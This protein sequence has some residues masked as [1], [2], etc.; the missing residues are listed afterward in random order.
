MV[1]KGNTFLVSG[2]SSGVGAGCVRCLADGGANVVIADI[3][4]EAG[5][6]LAEEIGARA[7]FVRTDVTDEASVTAAVKT[8]AELADGEL[9]GAISCAGIVHGERLV[10]REG[11]H[12]L[13][14]FRKILEVNAVGTFNMLRVAA[15]AMQGNDPID[16]ERG[17]LINT[18]SVAAFE[19]QIGQIAY[20]AS[21]GSVVAM[22]LPAARELARFG[23]R[24]VTIAP[25]IFD[26]PMMAV[27]PQKV[28]DS[29][30]QQVPFPS[31]FGTAEEYAALAAH[32]IENQ[33]LNGEVIRLDGAIRMMP[34]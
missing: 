20:A 3:N 30:E 29:L 6:A 34:K 4:V 27:M 12:D 7:V 26:T 9:R 25:G 19:G 8:A 16:A 21:K 32:I 11:P 13:A 31:R 1:I 10:G 24:V 22:T 23:I 33:M 5:E 18:A 17:V 14:R 2:G 15:A 28:R